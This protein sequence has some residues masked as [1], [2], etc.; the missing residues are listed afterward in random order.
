M[1]VSPSFRI[2]R[3][4]SLKSAEARARSSTTRESLPS[5]N[6]AGSDA[7]GAPS[8]LSRFVA[9]YIISRVRITDPKAMA[10]YMREAPPTV[11]AFGGRYLVRGND[12]QAIEGKWEHERMVVVEFPDKAAALA[13]Y[14]S[15][16]YAPLREVRQRSAETV[17]LLADGVP[18]EVGHA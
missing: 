18:L 16:Q 3:A 17:I 7:K 1:A 4:P 5:I 14:H 9:A 10:D 12:V 8:V 15:A 2:S 11:A 13:W 6:D